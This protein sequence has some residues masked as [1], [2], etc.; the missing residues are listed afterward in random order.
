MIWGGGSGADVVS[1]AGGVSGARDW[2]LAGGVNGEG[3]EVWLM[4]SMGK[5]A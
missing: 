2:T 1:G 3:G 4:E 5:Q